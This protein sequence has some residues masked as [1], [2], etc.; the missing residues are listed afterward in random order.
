VRCG[1]AASVARGRPGPRRFVLVKECTALVAPRRDQVGRALVRSRRVVVCGSRVLV[2]LQCQLMSLLRRRR[3]LRQPRDGLGYAMSRVDPVC[4]QF[5][6]AIDRRLSAL[7]GR[8]VSPLHVGGGLLGLV[9]DAFVTSTG[10]EIHTSG[11]RPSATR[12]LR[13]TRHNQPRVTLVRLPGIGIPAHPAAGNYPRIPGSDPMPQVAQA[14]T[15]GSVTT[16]AN[17]NPEL[18]SP[19]MAYADGDLAQSAVDGMTEFLAEARRYPLLS[20]AEEVDLAKRV[21]RGDLQ[22]KEKLISSN[23]RLVFSIAKH[24]QVST[25]LTLLDLV[26]EGM[27]GLI[28][29]AEKFDWRRGLKFSTY[30][31]LWIRQSIQR[32]LDNYGRV[33]RLPVTVAQQERKVAAASRRLVGTLGR[34]PTVEELSEATGL[35]VAQLT[36]LATAPRVA[37][38]LDRPVGDED[39]TLGALLPAGDAELGEEVYVGLEREQVRRAVAGLP[40]PEQSVIRLRFGLNGDP[41]PQ[42]YGVIAARLGLDAHRI[43]S[44]EKRALQQL[45]LH[46]ELRGLRAA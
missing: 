46:R 31:T 42:T 10:L 13:V 29:A 19:R 28:R 20:A 7:L 2:L 21:E 4:L 3:G 25:H 8:G 35:T 16:E 15:V 11:P 24:Y 40:E 5:A 32:G 38:S 14:T 37:T 17:H 39:T 22:A 23:L 36:D 9:N 26:Q 43:R 33:I 41:E 12:R 6:D 34:Q 44:I 45:A 18:S 30:A 1:D 27:L